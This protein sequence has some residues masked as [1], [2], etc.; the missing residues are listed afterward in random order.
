MSHLKI[1]WVRKENLSQDIVEFVQIN[2]D[3][4]FVDVVSFVLRSNLRPNKIMPLSQ[5]VE[6]NL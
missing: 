1:R 5:N 6:K 4:L 2:Y 3:C